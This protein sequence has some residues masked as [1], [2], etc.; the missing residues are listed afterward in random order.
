[1]HKMSCR[2]SVDFISVTVSTLI[3]PFWILALLLFIS[4]F[5]LK[6]VSKSVDQTFLLVR[7]FSLGGGR[8]NSNILRPSYPSTPQRPQRQKKSPSLPSPT[9][10]FLPHHILLNRIRQLR[11]L[12]PNCQLLH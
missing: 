9:H 3:V 11:C 7:Y 8:K 5:T 1:M 6:Y 10:L 12:G 2:R 4:P